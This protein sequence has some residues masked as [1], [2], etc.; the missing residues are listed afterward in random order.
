VELMPAITLDPIPA[1]ARLADLL[2]ALPAPAP[3]LPVV[4][5]CSCGEQ[6][7]L[8]AERCGFCIGEEAEDLEVAA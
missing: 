4:M 2:D 6:M 1:G 7:V 8:P 5:T 3:A